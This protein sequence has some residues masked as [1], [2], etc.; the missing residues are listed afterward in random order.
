MV[1]CF[2]WEFMHRLEGWNK[3]REEVLLIDWSD[4]L[5]RL[6]SLFGKDD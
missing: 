5:L 1:S 2:V 4:V 6:F 3:G